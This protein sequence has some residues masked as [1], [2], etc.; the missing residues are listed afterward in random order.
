[1]IPPAV[2]KRL[3]PPAAR[4]YGDPVRLEGWDHIPRGYG[5]ALRR[6]GGSWWLRLL[7][8]TP[9][10]DRFA[11]PLLVKRGHG[12]LSPSPAVLSDELGPV[13]S[14]WKIEPPGYEPPGSWAWLEWRR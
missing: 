2:P 7:W 6:P 8:R 14:G 10:L 3:V 11:H 1:M 12:Y 4:S 9:L 5:G 13:T